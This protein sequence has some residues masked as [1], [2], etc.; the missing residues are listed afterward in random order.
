MRRPDPSFLNLC[1]LLPLAVAFGLGIAVAAKTDARFVLWGMVALF[2][3][4]AMGCTISRTFRPFLIWVAAIGLSLF[5]GFGVAQ[6]ELSWGKDF[7]PPVSM[8]TVQATVAEVLSSG[9]GFRVLLLDRGR[10]CSED[11]PLPGKGRL[12]LRNSALPLHAGDRLE[13]R[14]RVKKPRNRGNPGEYDW[15]TH[16]R[17]RGMGWLS[18]AWNPDSVTVISH[19]A[20][21]RFSGALFRARESMNRFLQDY[22]GRYFGSEHRHEVRAVLKG[23]VLGD[24]GELGVNAAGTI[25]NSLNMKFQKSGL[26]HML[27][28]SGLHV[29]IVAL[30]AVAIARILVY[31]IPDLLLWLPFRK[32]AATACIPAIISYCLIVGARVP[33]QRATIMGVVLACSVL[34]DRKG[35]SFNT[36]A[37]AALAVLLFYPLSLFTPGFQLSFAAVVGILLTANPLFDRTW[38]RWRGSVDDNAAAD[39]GWPHQ[40]RW[41]RETI[42]RTA[43]SLLSVSLAANLAVTPFLLN[44]F[45]TFPTYGLL[46]NLLAGFLLPAALGVGLVATAVGAVFPSIGSILLIPADMLVWVIVRIAEVCADLPLATIRICHLGPAEFF[47]AICLGLSLLLFIRRPSRRIAFLVVGCLCVL[48]SVAGLGRWLGSAPN[49]RVTFLNVGFGDAAFIQPPGFPGVV[50]DGGMRAPYFDC[51]TSIVLPFLNWSG[52]RT[53]D[54]AVGTHPQSDHIGGLISVLGQISTRRLF[55]NVTEFDHALFL[56]LVRQAREHHTV[57]EHADRAGQSVRFQRA[58]ITFLN[59]P[60]HSLPRTSSSREVNNASVV[61]RMDYG[62]VSFLFTGDLE[63]EGE[64]EI[65][66]SRMP[67]AATV[68][69]VAHHGGKNSTSSRFLDAVRPKIVVISADYPSRRS[70]LPHPHVLQRLRACGARVFWTGRDGAI[71]ISSDGESV[72]HVA[73][74]RSGPAG[75]WK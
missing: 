71:T 48:L 27:S 72:T 25:D 55:L 7:E 13:F 40:N 49:L 14:A 47:L 68:L 66:A 41:F 75:S 45:H 51:G 52:V 61:F 26:S 58:T 1:P 16:C 12:F 32:I 74:G 37:A 35:S 50:V 20:P 39:V 31:G 57:L 24:R 21:G 4:S 6:R 59:R 43:I 54:G 28:A 2:A 3:A 44:S 15:E 73:T 53:L 22:S 23:I 64:E 8:V 62:K 10:N 67:V 34:L 19:G 36:L 70:V 29:G 5:V 42:P 18:S 38:I 17:D 69:K 65:L 33:A 56:D 46:A 11:K 63:R 30:L 60:Q 9:P